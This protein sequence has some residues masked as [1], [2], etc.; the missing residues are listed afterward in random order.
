MLRRDSRL[1]RTA[2]T[3]FFLLVIGYGVY[4]ARGILYGPRIHVEAP[5]LVTDPFF[6]VQGRAERIVELRLN[7][8]IISVTESGEF[9]EPLLLAEGSNR[10]ALEARDARGRLTSETLDI[11]YRPLPS[12]ASTTP[13]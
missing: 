11:V 5:A 2:L 3:L 8:A 1:V 6:H 9:D 13:L 4:E 12:E 7:G 10:I